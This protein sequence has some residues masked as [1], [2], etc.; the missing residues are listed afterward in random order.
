M[1]SHPRCVQQSASE[2][3]RR[4]G[5]GAARP[6]SVGSLVGRRARV[7]EKCP[8]L[9]ERSPMKTSLLG[10]MPLPPLRSP[11]SSMTKAAAPAA[12]RRLSFWLTGTDRAGRHPDRRAGTDRGGNKRLADFF[13]ANNAPRET[14]PA[15]AQTAG[16]PGDRGT[17]HTGTGD[18]RCG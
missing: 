5:R 6:S 4:P 7:V 11:D 12:Q 3:E 8:L 9:S 13:A 15:D 14:R 1:V 18:G 16:G 10:R 2:S 17:K